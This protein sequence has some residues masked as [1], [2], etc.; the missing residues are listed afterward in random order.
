MDYLDTIVLYYIETIE[1][2][3]GTTEH[4]VA[5]IQLCDCT[6]DHFDGTMEPFDVIIH[7]RDDLVRSWNDTLYYFDDTKEHGSGTAQYPVKN[8]LCKWYHTGVLW[9][10]NLVFGW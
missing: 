7:C 3:G 6:V 4:Y 10:H 9:W 1:Y 8:Q 2:D 5:T